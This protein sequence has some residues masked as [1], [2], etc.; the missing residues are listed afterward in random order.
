METPNTISDETRDVL[1]HLYDYA[2]LARHPLLTRYQ[3]LLGDNIAVAV[4]RLRRLVL[5]TIE[6]LQPRSSDQAGNAIH[7]ARAYV[8]LYNKYV[9]GQDTAA[10]EQEL[11]LGERQIQRE[12]RRAIDALAF[13]LHER[14]TVLAERQDANHTHDA[15]R[16]EIARAGTAPELFDVVDE[17]EKALASVTAL[18]QQYDVHLEW[19]TDVARMAVPGFPSLFRQLLVAALSGAVRQPQARRI[20]VRLRRQR[21]GMQCSVT[22]VWSP[23]DAPALDGFPPDTCRALAEALG[24]EL[25]I[26]QAKGRCC[27]AIVLPIPK[28]EYTIAVVEDNEDLI[29]L[30]SRYLSRHGY[31]LVGL[32]DSTT[33]VERIVELAPDAIVLD[34][35]MRRVD[36]WELLQRLKAEPS[37][38]QTPVAVCSVLNEPELATSLGADLYLRKPIRPTE[39]LE[40]LEQ[41]LR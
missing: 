31:R 32:T 24:T 18:A 35:M 37:L 25:R 11:S 41:L 38:W 40:N 33:A 17:I 20:V 21:D 1:V 22:L 30:Y 29:G 19:R 3:H 16:Q 36:G 15:L 14:L 23:T 9:L 12:Q 4:Q 34:I 8:I 26:D 27:L 10:L 5:D 6:S 28:E 7:R 13:A 39:L 2:Y